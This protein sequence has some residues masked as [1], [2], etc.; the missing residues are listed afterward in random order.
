[1]T[2]ANT[3][4]EASLDLSAVD[5]IDDQVRERLV[6]RLGPVLRVAVDR[7]RSQAR[8]RRRALDEIEE[9]L[10]VALQVDPERQPTRPGR[11]AVERRLATKRRRSERKADRGARWDPD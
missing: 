10:R 3:R 6:A 4:A 1:A 8:N 11:R 7:S 2:R 9:R 5:G